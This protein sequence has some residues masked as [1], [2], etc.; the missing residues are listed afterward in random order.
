MGAEGGRASAAESISWV[1]VGRVN[2]MAGRVS[3]LYAIGS[4]AKKTFDTCQQGKERAD[5]FHWPDRGE[6]KREINL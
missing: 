6:S 1:V 2:C 3:C 4:G 5:R